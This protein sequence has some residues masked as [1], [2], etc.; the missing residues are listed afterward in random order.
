MSL[1]ETKDNSKIHDK[2]DLIITQNKQILVDNESLK[3]QNKELIL[4]NN[5]LNVKLKQAQ[6]EISIMT[7][8]IGKLSLSINSLTNKSYS[9]QS[10]T[11]SLSTQHTSNIL[12][13]K[14]TKQKNILQKLHSFNGVAC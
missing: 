5:I 10:P 3:K 14:T 4:S 8:Q 1:Y 9:T 13:K 6:Q 11:I 2:L 7:Q 12:P